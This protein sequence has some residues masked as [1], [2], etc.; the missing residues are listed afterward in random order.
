MTDRVVLD[1]V[2]LPVG[3]VAQHMPAGWM[4]K[5]LQS[6]V[7]TRTPSTWVEVR[8]PEIEDILAAAIAVRIEQGSDLLVHAGA[9]AWQGSAV[10]IPG[11]SG[12]GKSTLAA[13]C[14]MRGM[15]YM[16]DEMV[17]IDLQSLH[18]TGFGRPIMLTPWSA[19]QLGVARG[20]A[21]TQTT[22]AKIDMAPSTLGGHTIVEA[23]PVRH[24]VLPAGKELP[25]PSV[26]A[27]PMEVL[28]A[29]LQSSFNHYRF[30]EA[31][32][33]ACAE[34]ARESAGW[35]LS[36]MHPIDAGSVIAALAQGQTAVSTAAK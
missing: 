29:L 10:I 31:A 35:R 24:V 21:L 11:A 33:R 6:L 23:L 13:S 20:G 17:A 9:V 22:A 16:T 3:V 25:T 18:I 2:G 14:V 28:A 19:N 7:S 4:S 34:L 12:C 36:T 5:R 15:G 32:W 30:G 27:S 26:A 1:I 8:S